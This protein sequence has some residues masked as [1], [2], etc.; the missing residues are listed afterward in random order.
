MLKKLAFFLA[1]GVMANSSATRAQQ[2][3]FNVPSQDVL[4]PQKVYGE[5][6]IPFRVSDPKYVAITPRI[7]IGLGYN[8]EGG[9]NLPGYIDN[10]PKLW[11][12]MLTL[13]RHEVFD[14]TT[15]T[16]GAHVHL[17]LTAGRDLGLFGHATVGQKIGSSLRAAGGLYG[18]DKNVTG[19]TGGVGF[20]GSVEA[21]IV[22]WLTLAIDGYSGKHALGYITPGVAILPAPNLAIYLAYQISNASRS[23]DSFLM[24][25]GYTL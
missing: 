11:T 15:L 6:G 14:A 20:L 2:T 4:D 23:A 17:P 25:F 13:K 1:L 21:P 5:I 7:V 12:A 19:T 18:A 16:Y 24:V 10:G 9:V 8:F 22:D 3:V